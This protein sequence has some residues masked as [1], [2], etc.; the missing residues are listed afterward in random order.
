MYPY[1]KLNKQKKLIMLYYLW[2]TNKQE[3]KNQGSNL[4][5]LPWF[6]FIR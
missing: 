6:T 5:T 1:L 2:K 3:M 4:Y